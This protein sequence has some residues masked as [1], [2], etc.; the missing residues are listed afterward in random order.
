MHFP[1]P[2][3]SAHSSERAS[4]V[5]D[6]KLA[7]MMLGIFVCVCVCVRG[8]GAKGYFGV[9]NSNANRT[10]ARSYDRRVHS[11]GVGFYDDSDHFEC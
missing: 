7:F 10:C 4:A 5:E 1:V 6:D 3:A 2:F 9:Q 8:M 11:N